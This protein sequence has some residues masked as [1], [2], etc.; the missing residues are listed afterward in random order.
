M[1]LAAIVVLSLTAVSA[2]VMLATWW[3]L[4]RESEVPATRWEKDF[5][6]RL[7]VQHAASTSGRNRQKQIETVL[8]EELDRKYVVAAKNLGMRLPSQ[9]IPV[10]EFIGR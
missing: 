3:S 9:E 7:S 2:L 6:L 10:R 8:F 5:A 1:G 4:R